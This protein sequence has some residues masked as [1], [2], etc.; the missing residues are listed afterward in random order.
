MAVLTTT[1]QK[2]TAWIEWL[3]RCLDGKFVNQLFFGK[4]I[5]GVPDVWA[6][7]IVALEL[8]L[9]AG[10]Y[11][12]KSAWS[13]NFRGIGGASCT[14]SSSGKCSLHGQGIAIDIDPRL[15]PYIRTSV[16]RWTST[17]FTPAQVALLE[18]IRNTKGEQL[19]FWGGRWN[20]IKDYMHWE[21]NVDPGSTEVDWATVP[22]ATQGD[23]VTI[24]PKSPAIHVAELQKIMA[25]E[26]D[27]DNGTWDPLEG[28]SQF[29]DQS[30]EAGEDGDW[31]DTCTDNV[32]AMQQ[33]LGYAENGSLVDDY[34]WQIIT[35]RNY[36]GGETDL[37]NYYTKGQV[38]NRDQTYS[39]AR[40]DD[41]FITIGEGVK[42]VK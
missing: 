7:A 32:I 9:R 30:F 3:D 29:D 31:G 14:C 42:I 8:T 4:T 17:A 35:V 24:T 6:D 26:F 20:S 12:P 28:K 21:T 39:K 41:R 33:A 37:S 15:N 2:R 5:G 36:S 1:R 22:G 19:W 40:A 11:T 27:A 34:L 10:G 16:F 18:G 23:G 13:Y 25:E 38:F